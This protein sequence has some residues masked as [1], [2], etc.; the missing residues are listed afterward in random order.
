MNNSELFLSINQKISD[1]LEDR[2]YNHEL[3]K[4]VIDNICFDINEISLE[5]KVIGLA[6][7]IF[8]ILTSYH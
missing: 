3:F 1:L 4:K 7:I 6:H 5:K 8:V 2:T